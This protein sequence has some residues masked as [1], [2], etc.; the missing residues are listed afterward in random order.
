MGKIKEGTL[1]LDAD[2]HETFSARAADLEKSFEETKGHVPSL[3]RSQIAIKAEAA[4]NAEVDAFQALKSRDR[5]AEAQWKRKVLSSGTLSDKIASLA[6]DV[7][8]SPVQSL[9]ALDSLLSMS[10]KK[11]R[12]EAELSIDALRDL[13]ASNLLPESRLLVSLEKR[14]LFWLRQAAE[15]DAPLL[16]LAYFE[17]ELKTRYAGFVQTLESSSFEALDHF[18]RIA[19]R[20]VYE[21]LAAR[22]EQEQQL[23]SQLV[24]KLGDPNKKIASQVVYYLRQ[25]VDKH[26]NMRPIVV[27]EI[28]QI[29]RRP[30]ISSR[31]SYYAVIFLNHIILVR[32]ADHELASQLIRVYLGVFKDS[33]S[34]EA[35]SSKSS[36][37]NIKGKKGKHGGKKGGK[38]K[39]TRGATGK[40]AHTSQ[41]QAIQSNARLLSAL[42]TGVNRAFPYTNADKSDF[43][44]QIDTLFKMVHVGTFATATQALMLLLQVMRK[45]NASSDRFYRT[46]YAKLMAPELLKTSKPT[47]FLNLLYR[48]MRGDSDDARLCAFLRRI[49]QVA[50]CAPAS[51]AAGLML[52]LSSILGSKEF[53][54]LRRIVHSSVAK[55]D[56]EENE[57]SVSKTKG[58]QTPTM[59]INIG[60]AE[61]D[62]RPAAHDNYAPEK[63]DPVHASANGTIAWE[64]ETLARHYHPSVRAFSRSILED[65]R[66]EIS[67]GGNPIRDLSNAAFLDRFSYRN[68]KKRD[69]NRLRSMDKV[70]GDQGREARTG[71]ASRSVAVN[72]VQFLDK[73]P[74]NVPE[75][76]RFFHKFFK[77]R[78]SSGRHDPSKGNAK[79]TWDEEDDEEEAFAQQLAEQLMRDAGG[80]VDDGDVDLDMDYTD[81]ESEPDSDAPKTGEETEVEWGA[82]PQDSDDENDQGEDGLDFGAFDDDDDEFSDDAGSEEDVAPQKKKKKGTYSFVDAEEFADILDNAGKDT[83]HAAQEKWEARHDGGSSGGGGGGGGKRKRNGRGSK[84]R[85]RRR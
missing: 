70:F 7:Q 57:Q 74:R 71:R 47:L 5:S 49:L 14:E 46:L 2:W 16:A 12:R 83:K 64:L 4:F 19:I 77:Q 48:S 69:Q 18:K 40:A 28:E 27:R 11:G 45:H 85:K 68:P 79:K 17:S 59:S 84:G 35:A 66:C 41:D 6:L 53:I 9:W 80:N 36:A 29:L 56:E 63:R 61:R 30:G 25:L 33:F 39:A 13:F 3:P 78:Q 8:E 58:D 42:L 54:P 26:K 43:A 73:A 31:T 82:G 52:L 65:A 72:S 51:L 67:Y 75:N 20:S 44:E 50:T 60:G 37:K 23:L 55:H 21:L 24:N 22:P 62:A 15:R 10:K 1:S 81:S 76:E 32:D 34:K 38:K